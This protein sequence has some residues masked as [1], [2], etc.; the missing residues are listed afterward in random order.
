[1][2]KIILYSSSSLEKIPLTGGVRR[3]IELLNHLGDFCDLTLLSGDKEY[4]VPNGVKHISMNHADLASKEFV[5]AKWNRKYLKQMKQNNPYDWIISFDVPP[6]L[7]LA[8]FKMP[9]LCLMIRKDFIGYER[10]ILNDMKYSSLKKSLMLFLF[11]F[12]EWITLSHAEKIIVQCEYDKNELL[13]RH[14]LSANKLK[15]T[16]FV[17]INNVNP[18]WAVFSEKSH[19][20]KNKHFMIGSVNGFADSRKGCDLFL[21]AVAELIDEGIQLEAHI[22]GDGQSMK[23][24]QQKYS[25]YENIIFDGRISKPSEYVKQFD[26]AVVPSRA[27]SCPNTVMEALFNGVPVIASNVGG[28]PEILNDPDPLFSPDVSALKEKIKYYMVQEHLEELSCRQRIRKDELCF[29][30]VKYIY[31][32]LDNE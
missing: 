6:A 12:A 32:L 30:W 25:S 4:T 23:T 17:Q 16:I 29:D 3:F 9:H 21:S 19:Q 14:R 8:L 24:Y 5:Y 26:L 27:D 1:M 18:S 11:S 10:I 28:I 13:K 31:S 20:D 7:W 22:A 15:N 2:K